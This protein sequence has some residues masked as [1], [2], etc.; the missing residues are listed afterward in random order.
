L[1]S[2]NQFE[3]AKKYFLRAQSEGAD[4][5]SVDLGLANAELALGQTQSAMTRLHSLSNDPDISQDYEYLLAMGNAYQ[6]EHQTPEALGMFARANEI[7]QGNDYARETEI[8]LAGEEGRQITDTVSGQ[9]Q[10]SLSPI[11]EDINIYQLDARIRCLSSNPNCPASPSNPTAALLPPPR[12]SVE[13]IGVARYHV[14]LG[15]WPTITGMFAER[16]ARGTSFFPSIGTVQ[17]RNT[18]D[19]IFNVGVSPVFHAFGSTISLNPGVQFTLRRDATAPAVMNQNL[20]RQYLYLYTGSFGNWVSVSG[21]LIREAGPFT[22]ITL[23][24]RD[25][26]GNIEFQVGRPWARTSL[27]TGYEG[28]DE[29]TRPLVR[30]YFTTDAYIGL[31]RKF[32]SAWRAAVLAEYLRSWR[33]QD[34]SY[35]IAQAIRPGF[36]LDYEPLASRWAVHANGTWSQGKG[37]HAYDNVTSEV[38]VDYVKGLRR[39]MS[40]GMGDVPVNYPL[41]ISF[42]IQQQ[43]FYDFTGRNRNTILPVIRLNLF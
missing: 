34:A 1:V 10:L 14:R 27:L 39:V 6:Q 7:M 41:R 19:T 30:E 28:R 43:N 8:R 18:Y 5:E 33:V 42:G 35:A 40:D 3:V 12:S 21:S 4:Q 24:S 11:F 16:N 17:Y 22:E 25:F 31:Q 20:F 15:G 9:P 23:H 2:I 32:G 37:F 13:T 38:M 29:L 26:S 36:R